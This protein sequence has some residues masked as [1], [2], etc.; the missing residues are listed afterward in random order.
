MDINY[1]DNQ[2]G[3]KKGHSAALCTSAVKQTIEY[4]INRGF[5]CF[6][7]FSHVFDNVNYWK[8]FEQLLADGVELCFVHLLVFTA[9]C[10]A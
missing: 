10:D 8:L 7:D 6:V 1:N 9:R 2:F 3:F 5:A 4:Y